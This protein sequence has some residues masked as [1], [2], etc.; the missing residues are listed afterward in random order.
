MPFHNLESELENKTVLVTGA[1]GGLGIQIILL[2]NELR[3]T[4][5]VNI[6]IYASFRD[7]NKAKVLFSG[8]DIIPLVQD[9]R[10]PLDC[11]VDFDY[12]FHCA[13]P[14][15]PSV[16]NDKPEEVLTVNVTSTSEIL[17][18]AVRHKCQGLVFASTH[19]VYGEIP[20]KDYIS[21]EDIGIIDTLSPRSCYAQG[22]RAAET[23]LACYHKKYGLRAMSARL[24][25]FFGSYM[26]MDSGLFIC[27]FI[28]DAVLKRPVHIKGD[29]SLM[30]P[31]CYSSDIAN[32]M[33]YILLLGEEGCAYNVQG[34]EVTIGEVANMVAEL[35]RVPVKYDKPET[36]NHA[37]HGQS[38]NINK[39]QALGWTPAVGLEYG[40]QKVLEDFS[41]K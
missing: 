8:I 28:N 24:C 15:G 21:E 29:A 25:R 9:I 34:Y 38:L 40:I 14:V 17:D 1:S 12:I 33:V 20:N 11:T 4:Q 18:Y 10:N 41:C 6:C 27:D 32:A 23:L 36:T 2:L 22:K 37:A 3:K 16:F 19:E 31:L 7:R 30:R 13:G 5:N 35:G 26:N 39:L